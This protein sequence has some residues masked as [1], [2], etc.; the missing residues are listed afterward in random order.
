VL[1][2]TDV[3]ERIN[4]TRDSLDGGGPMPTDTL[5]HHAFTMLD[6]LEARA[7]A[8]LVPNL[9]AVTRFVES[10]TDLEWVRPDGGNVAFPRVRGLDDTSELA[11]RLEREHDTAIVPGH[12]FDAPSHFRIAFGVSSDTLAGGLERIGLALDGRTAAPVS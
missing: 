8:I 4:R 12:F 3:V 1:A 5:A 6:R 7:K 10:R 2:S 9:E 11:A